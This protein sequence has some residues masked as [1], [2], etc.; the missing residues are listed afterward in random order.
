MLFKKVGTRAALDV[1]WM[2]LT[3]VR[4]GAAHKSDGG[5]KVR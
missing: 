2:K 5:S 3:G 1:R 4:S